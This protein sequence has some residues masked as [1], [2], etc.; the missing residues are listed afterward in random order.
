MNRKVGR[1]GLAIG[2][3]LLLFWVGIESDAVFAALA[4]GWQL[5]FEALG[6]GGLLDRL[7]H[8]TSAQ[9]TKRSLPAMLTYGVLYLTVC[10]LLLWLVLH[11]AQAWR[12]AAQL[13]AGAIVLCAGLL[14]LGKLGGDVAVFYHAARRLIDFLVSPVPVLV[15]I[16]LL[17]PAVRRSLGWR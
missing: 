1:W 8:G 13:Y 7:Q 2:L 4:R 16:P 15:L 9:V 5:V 12:L 3:T 11:D 14:L 6:L 10:L 17:S